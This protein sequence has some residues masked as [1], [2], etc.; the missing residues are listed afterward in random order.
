MTMCRFSVWSTVMKPRASVRCWVRAAS[1][2]IF[3]HTRD[4]L[5]RASGQQ[6]I[7]NGHGQQMIVNVHEQQLIVN[8]ISN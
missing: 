2:Q 3:E 5:G 7:V 6:L 8:V 1:A 4:C